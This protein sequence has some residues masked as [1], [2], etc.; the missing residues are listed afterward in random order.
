MNLPPILKTWK[1]AVI[2]AVVVI[3]VLVLLAQ[4]MGWITLF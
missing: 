1:G 3:L 4:A 2:V